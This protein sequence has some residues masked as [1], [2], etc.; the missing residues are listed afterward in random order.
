MGNDKNIDEILDSLDGVKRATPAGFFYTRLRARMEKEAG[1]A[2]SMPR[3]LK[4][5]WIIGM[6]AV[7]LIINAAVILRTDNTTDTNPVSESEKLQSIASDYN[8][9]DVGSLYD[10]NEDK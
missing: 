4:P 9:N 2:P 8:M 10:L 6:L 7:V 5:V 1:N 3:V